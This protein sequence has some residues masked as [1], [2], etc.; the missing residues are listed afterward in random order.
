[1]RCRAEVRTRRTRQCKRTCSSIFTGLCS[2]HIN[3]FFSVHA[4]RIQ[5]RF[6]GR[7]CRRYLNAIYLNLPRDL[8]RK[9]LL[10]MREPLLIE[11]HHF[12][13]IRNICLKYINQVPDFVF[14][15]ADRRQMIHARHL[16]LK[17]SSILEV[18]PE[19]Y[20]WIKFVTQHYT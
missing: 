7:R 16:M 10:H 20:K 19:A 6:R 5:S 11:K 1:M 15:D 4:I 18:E 3:I 12:A 8:Q 2:Q 14:D 13:P 9:V 17:Y